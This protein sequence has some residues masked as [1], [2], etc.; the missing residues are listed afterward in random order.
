MTDDNAIYMSSLST[1]NPFS[2]CLKL[3]LKLIKSKKFEQSNSR[4][5]WTGWTG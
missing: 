1:L 3:F 2:I 5:A 4:F